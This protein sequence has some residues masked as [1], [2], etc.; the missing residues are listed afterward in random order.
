VGLR[1][2]A[3]ARVVG[4]FRTSIA[5]AKEPELLL[6]DGRSSRSPATPVPSV[7]ARSVADWAARSRDVSPADLAWF[8]V[9]EGDALRALDHVLQGPDVVPACR[10]QFDELAAAARTQRRESAA[11]AAR[12]AAVRRR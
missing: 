7:D 5:A 11:I 12:L 10:G 8:L 9:V 1:L 3:A 4:A 2:S 6:K